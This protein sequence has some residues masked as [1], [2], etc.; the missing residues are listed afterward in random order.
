MPGRGGGQRC[1]GVGLATCAKSWKSDHPGMETSQTISGSASIGVDFPMVNVEGQVSG[2]VTTSYSYGGSKGY[3][4]ACNDAGNNMLNQCMSLESQ[5]YSQNHC[6]D[7]ERRSH[8]ITSHTA[9]CARRRG[10]CYGGVVCAT[11]A[12]SSFH[13]LSVAD[14]RC[15]CSKSTWK[16]SR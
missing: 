16:S 4:T 11:N 8:E 10:R 9:I 14:T 7:S 1:H 6:S 15:N 13:Q 12:A 5:C 3:L 2:S